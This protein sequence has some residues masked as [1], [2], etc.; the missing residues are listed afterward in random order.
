MVADNVETAGCQE[1]VTTVCELIET[2]QVTLLEFIRGLGTHLTDES[3][4]IRTRAITLLSSV[5]GNLNRKKMYAKD[6]QVLLDFYLS[7]LDDEPC[8][9][10]VLKGLSSLVLMSQF[11]PNLIP[12]LL[13]FL[14][15]KYSPLGKLASVRYFGFEVLDSTLSAHLEPAKQYNDEIIKTY[16][17]VSK[18]EKDPKNLLLSFKLSALIAQNFDISKFSEEMFDA[19]FCYFP[20][21]FRAPANDPYKITGDQLKQALR[22]CL[23]ASDLYAKDAFP[24]LL[25][26]LSAT[27]PTVKLDVL[28]TLNQCVDKYSTATVEEYWITLWNSLKYEILHNELASVETLTQLFEYYENSE[29]EDE[30]IIPAV[31][32]IFQSLSSKLQNVND[33]LNIKDYLYVIMDELAKN[34]KNHGDNKSKQ[35]TVILAAL[36]AANINV[37]NLLIPQVMPLLLISDDLTVKTQRQIL[38]N[39]SFM[40]DSYYILFNEKQE[41]IHPNNPMYEFKDD[42]LML[43][44][45]AL[46]STSKVEV[47]LRCLAVKLVAK[48]VSLNFFLADQE[49]QLITQLV[50]DVLLEDDNSV[51]EKQILQCFKSLSVGYPSAVLEITVPKLFSFLPD[52]DKDLDQLNTKSRVLDILISISESKLVIDSV[53][54]RLVGKIGTLIKSASQ[55][56]VRSVF[57]TLSKIAGNLNAK[58]STND[59]MKRLVPRLFHVVLDADKTNHDEVVL[60][61]TGRVAKK[62]VLQTDTFQHEEI[63]RDAIDLFING[64]PTS[65]VVKQLSEPLDIIKGSQLPF[66]IFTKIISAVDKSVKFPIESSSFLNLLFQA[67]KLTVQFSRLSVLQCISLVVNKWIDDSEYLIA[68]LEDFK[69]ALGDSSIPVK[70]RSNTLEVLIWIGKALIMKQHACA[71]PY[72][73]YLLSLFDSEELHVFTPKILEILVADVECYQQFKKPGPLNRPVVFNMNVR[74]LYKQKLFNTVLPLLVSKFESSKNQTYLLALSLMLKYVDKSI[75][76]PHVGTLLPLVLRSLT[77]DSNVIVTSSLSILTIAVNESDEL[78]SRHLSTVIPNLLEIVNTHKNEA[79]KRNA[80]ECLLSLTKYD[81][82]LLVPYKQDIIRRLAKVLDDPKRSIRRLACDCRQAYYELGMPRQ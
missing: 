59:N 33:D 65:L 2:N 20:I 47:S 6:V 16:L 71:P 69:Q 52:D 50:T 18:N 78:V 44:N 46:L 12:H 56:Y 27:S 43:F 58:D 75:I 38:T 22:D 24:N 68:I 36:C 23:S 5:L 9:R 19:V 26:K 64:K 14:V 57:L 77:T 54:L 55:S 60:E 42:L 4:A 66:I 72:E 34:I 62:I 51:T 31:L 79:V 74:L 73:E 70:E 25:E 67:N 10:E 8:L 39:V 21:S 15:E 29:N 82:H 63:L 3:N 35:S 48:V 45:K 11:D 13:N 40:V 37:Y 61:Y 7:K 28:T 49:A 41:S 80:L 32:K 76:V 1:A 81:L 17:H 53:M 30:R